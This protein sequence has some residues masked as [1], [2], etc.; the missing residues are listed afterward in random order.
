MKKFIFIIV[1]CF[2]IL[3]TMC[4][5]NKQMFD[6]NYMFTKAHVKIDEEWVDF[7]IQSWTDYEDGEQIQIKLKDGTV[8]IVHSLNCILYNGT[9]PKVN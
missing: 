7:E 3:F 9:L 2:V 1:S 8:M 5:C 6:W 4:G